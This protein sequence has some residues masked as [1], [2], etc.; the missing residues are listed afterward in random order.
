[1][2]SLLVCKL[3]KNKHVY[4]NKHKY[5]SYLCVCTE[6]EKAGPLV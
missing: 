5:T 2:F 1:M 4:I 3:Q 6:G